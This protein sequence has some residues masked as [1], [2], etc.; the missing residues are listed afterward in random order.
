MRARVLE[1]NSA[2]MPHAHLKKR[3]YAM[4]I[5]D[6]PNCKK[7][8]QLPDQYAGQLVKCPHC[9]DTFTAPATAFAPA[10]L[11]APPPATTEPTW[12]DQDVV[13]RARRPRRRYEEEDEYDDDIRDISRG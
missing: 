9:Q 8:L 13:R 12:E 10:P 6:C 5:I 7:G 4:P 2:L 1:D 3:A 11:V